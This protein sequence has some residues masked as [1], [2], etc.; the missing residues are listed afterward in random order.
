MSIEERLAS[1][2]IPASPSFNPWSE[3]TLP[4]PFR[5]KSG[6]ITEGSFGG[7][8]EVILVFH[9]RRLQRD[10][11]LVLRAEDFGEMIADPYF[12]HD[13]GDETLLDSIASMLYANVEEA[14]NRFVTSPPDQPV[15]I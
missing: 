1:R 12:P 10:V 8:G 9:H 14:L 2:L 3:E 5:F 4:T 6:T 7:V 11:E 15:V 13:H